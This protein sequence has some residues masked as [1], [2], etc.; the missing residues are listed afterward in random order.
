MDGYEAITHI[1][2]SQKGQETPIIALTAHAFEEDRKKVMEHGADDFVRKPFRE[3]EIFEMLSKHLGVQFVYEPGSEDENQ[4]G[5]MSEQKMQQAIL[6]LPE[7]LQNSLKTAV[8]TVDFD[9]TNALLESVGGK[10]KVLANA[11][12]ELTQKYQFDFLQKLFEN[13]K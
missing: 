5:K 12:S 6:D 8:D 3:Y 7:A 1:K 11:L 4:T 9:S 13:A 2:A 10:N